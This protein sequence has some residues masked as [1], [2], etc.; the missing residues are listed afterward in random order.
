MTEETSGQTVE[1]AEQEEHSPISETEISARAMGWRPQD[2]FRGDPEKWVDADTFVARGEQVMP[3]LKAQNKKLRQ[4]MD[5]LRSTLDEFKNHTA[6]A[7]KA[8][9]E[10]ILTTIRQLKAEA[11]ARGDGEALVQLED[12]QARALSKALELEN[13]Q[14][15]QAQPR[16]SQEDQQIAASWQARN[17]WYGKDSE[18]TR[19]TD[20]LGASLVNI[21]PD[22]DKVELFQQI[23]Q[24]IRR[25]YPHK[26]QRKNA[27]ASPVDNGRPAARGGSKSYNA[28][29]ADAKAACDRMVKQGVL[30]REEYVKYY[31]WEK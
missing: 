5:E 9:I 16:I 20:V 4:E 12:Q 29:P 25:Q 21:N 15:K 8:E 22:I 2:E 17:Q 18:L 13:P 31:E 1:P 23:D 7:Q 27:G 30:T 6:R 24:I 10:Q 19:A 3:L 11:V 14:K 28:L 26:F